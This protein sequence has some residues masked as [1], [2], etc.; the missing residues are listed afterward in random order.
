MITVGST[1]FK[2]MLLAIFIG[3][4]PVQKAGPVLIEG[5]VL[6]EKTGLPV[7]HAHVYILDGEEEALT[8]NNGDFSI[9]SWQRTPFKLTVERQDAYQKTS[10]VVSDPLKK[11]VIRLK[12]R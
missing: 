8:D 1:F 4:G 5:K 12:D 11:Q 7:Y 3:S 10:V 9:K 2:Y 6:A